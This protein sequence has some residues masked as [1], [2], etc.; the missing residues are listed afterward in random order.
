MVPGGWVVSGGCVVP[1]GWV[2]SGG[3]VVPGGS[4]VSGGCVVPGGSMVSGGWVVSAVTTD[5]GKQSLL[6][7]LC[8]RVGMTIRMDEFGETEGVFPN[9]RTYGGP[10]PSRKVTF[11]VELSVWSPDSP[12]SLSYRASTLLALESKTFE[13]PLMLSALSSEGGRNS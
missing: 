9:V 6:L 2:V 7:L 8:V 5:L 10:L 4:V 12:A 13:S 11:F 3:C 1:G